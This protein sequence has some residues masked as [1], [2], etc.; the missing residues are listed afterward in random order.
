MIEMVKKK[1]DEL[2][3]QLIVLFVC[4]CGLSR[5]LSDYFF[6]LLPSD[7]VFFFLVLRGVITL[8]SHIPLPRIILL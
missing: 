1:D 4:F 2:P 8:A 3:K 5:P 6:S 7:M